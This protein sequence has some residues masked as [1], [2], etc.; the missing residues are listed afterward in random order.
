MYNTDINWSP[1]TNGSSI[2]AGEPTLFGPHQTESLGWDYVS[3]Y[4]PQ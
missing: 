3:N 2:W 1:Q 4:T